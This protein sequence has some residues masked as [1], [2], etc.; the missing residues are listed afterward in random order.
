MKT[1]R[2]AMIIAAFFAVIFSA[3]PGQAQFEGKIEYLVSADGK[4]VN[5]SYSSKGDNMRF[6]LLKAIGPI[7][8]GMSAIINMEDKQAI[9]LMKEQKMAMVTSID[10]L[11]NIAARQ[12]SL[13]K[14]DV[15]EA[16]IIKTGKTKSIAGYSC[17]Q[18]VLRSKKQKKGNETLEVWTAKQLGGI[19]LLSEL[20]KDSQE[21]MEKFDEALGKNG[22]LPLLVISKDNKGKETL[23]LEATNVSK[24]EI[25]DATFQTPAGYQIIDQSKMQMDG[26][27]AEQ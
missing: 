17:E 10:G 25:T 1:T 13:K 19:K 8:G 23:R 18:W 3:V 26:E 11:T 2:M 27:P 15:D 12:K 22:G 20:L 7:P 21:W 9:L 14:K 24:D 6:D 4:D 5:V 16:T